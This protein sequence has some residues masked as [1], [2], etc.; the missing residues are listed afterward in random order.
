MAGEAPKLHPD[1][2]PVRRWLAEG[3]DSG[4]AI[5]MLIVAMM[6]IVGLYWLD[7]SLFW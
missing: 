7:R 3:S 4:L 1:E 6:V 5:V 2:G